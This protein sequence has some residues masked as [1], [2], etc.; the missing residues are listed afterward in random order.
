[1][2]R[3][4]YVLP[5]RWSAPRPVDELTKYLAA[6]ASRFDDVVVVDGSPPAVFA[7]HHRRW[8][9]TVTHTAPDPAFASANGKVQGVRTGIA[10]TAAE[11]IVIADDD[12][13]YD[14]QPLDRVLGALD[15]S[16]LVWP[17]NYF[18]PLPWHAR[19]D[20]ARTLLNRAVGCDFPGTVGVRRDMFLAMGAYDG[21]V[22]WENL[23]LRRT[24]EAAGGRIADLPDTFVRRL[25]PTADH[26]RSQRVRQ[27]YDE[28][29]RPGHL[30]VE[31]AVVPAALLAAVTTI[32]LAE[33]GRRRHR[34]T[35]VFPASASLLAPAW[36]L[37]RGVC[38]WLA[39]AARRRDGGMRY[40]DTVLRRAATPTRQLRA[41]LAKVRPGV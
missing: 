7:D 6:V 32:L 12:V 1:M 17:Q 11:L 34:G 10:R 18:D 31:L 23:E 25:P 19:W 15:E 35:T 38:A 20:T 28:L 5:I 3:T 36:L 22:L 21:D 37:E 4:A 30:A 40:H 24:V 27:A 14:E 2:A 33:V 41:R 13:R 26:F 9:S 16:D 39:L 29:A 8:R